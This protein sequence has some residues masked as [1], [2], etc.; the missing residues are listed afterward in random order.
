MEKKV[1]VI[2]SGLSEKDERIVCFSLSKNKALG[3]AKAL[4]ISTHCRVYEVKS[5][6]GLF[7]PSIDRVLI[8]SV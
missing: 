7:W 5:C 3:C 4:S 8:L 1:Y 6:E 2:C